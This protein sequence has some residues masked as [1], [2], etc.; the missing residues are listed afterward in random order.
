MKRKDIVTLVLLV[1][2]LAVAYSA[3]KRSGLDRV[4]GDVFGFLGSGGAP[5]PREKPGPTSV[6][7][8]VISGPITGSGMGGGPGSFGVTSSPF[9][10]NV[11]VVAAGV[12]LSSRNAPTSGAISPAVAAG[13]IGPGVFATGSSPW[14]KGFGGVSPII[15]PPAGRATFTGSGGLATLAPSIVHG[16]RT[17]LGARGITSDA[18]LSSM[19]NLP[20][21]LSAPGV[22]VTDQDRAAV[23]AGR[24][25]IAVGE[26][27]QLIYSGG[28]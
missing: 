2:G 12:P 18:Q 26:G 3:V 27:G 15:E 16:I 6:I 8:D 28:A 25:P 7:G 11:G 14:P 19:I 10:N 1:V 17:E 5:L 4:V 13:T 23:A 9:A 24:V 21:L 20:A 22:N